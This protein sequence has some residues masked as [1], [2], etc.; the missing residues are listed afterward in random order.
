MKKTINTVIKII[1]FPFA[2]LFF[3]PLMIMAMLFEGVDGI[4]E[5]SDIVWP[6]W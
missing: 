4:S 3:I 5:I 1:R 6:D 2:L